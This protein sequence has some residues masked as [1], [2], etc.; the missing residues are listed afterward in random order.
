[1]PNTRC[2]T[3][4]A[5][6]CST[7]AWARSSAKQVANRATGPIARSVAPSSNPS[8]SEVSSPPSNAA[9]TSRPSTTS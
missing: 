2:A 3:I 9:T 6:V 8:P 7:C 1:M 5:M 4:A